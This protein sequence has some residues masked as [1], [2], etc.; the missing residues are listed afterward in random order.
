MRVHSGMLVDTYLWLKPTN[1]FVKQFL[2]RRVVFCLLVL[3]VCRAAPR[4]LSCAFVVVVFQLIKVLVRFYLG[5][6]LFI[7]DIVC[8]CVLLYFC[9]FV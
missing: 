6:T 7:C 3:C 5:L 8:Q 9:I 1:K 2:Q 4:S